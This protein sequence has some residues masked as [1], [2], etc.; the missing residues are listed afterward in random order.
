MFTKYGPW[1]PLLIG[2]RLGGGTKLSVTWNCF[3]RSSLAGDYS[4]KGLRSI[5]TLPDIVKLE[6]PVGIG[7]LRGIPVLSAG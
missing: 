1:D 6:K 2:G 3:W 7:M 5:N 4:Y